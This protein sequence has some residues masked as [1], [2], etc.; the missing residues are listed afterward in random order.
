MKKIITRLVALT[1]L[2]SFVISPVSAAFVS[3]PQPVSATTAPSEEKI[4]EAMKEFRSLSKKEK[5]EKVKE[6]KKVL[7]QLK[8]E[9]KSGKLAD[10]DVDTAL[11]VILAIFI[12]PLAV[13]LHQNEINS[14]FW[15]SLVLTLIFWI[16]G[17]IYSLLV[18]LDAI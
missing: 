11:L 6:A 2:S 3:E 13:Y 5:K 8:A 9:K 14:K 12:P 10:G 1:I 7:K 15:I 16:P 18:V 17:V 4:N